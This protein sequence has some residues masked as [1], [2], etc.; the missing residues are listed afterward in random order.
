MN[1]LIAILL[2]VSTLA[3]A[4]EAERQAAYEDMIKAKQAVAKRAIKPT[5]FTGVPAGQILSTGAYAYSLGQGNYENNQY[6]YGSAYGAASSM[7][8]YYTKATLSSILNGGKW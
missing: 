2:V 7:L 5:I 4:G 1:K 8:P 6:A 3:H